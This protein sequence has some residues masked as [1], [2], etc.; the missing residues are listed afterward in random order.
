MQMLLY[1]MEQDLFMCMMVLHMCL[2]FIEVLLAYNL[3][4]IYLEA[5]C[6]IILCLELKEVGFFLVV[7]LG[8]AILLECIT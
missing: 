6:L 8:E 3:S 7:L 1:K 2:Q 5:S 4:Q